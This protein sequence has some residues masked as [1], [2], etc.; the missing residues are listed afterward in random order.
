M[1]DDLK[2]SP[3]PLAEISQGP[4]AFE[5]F[6]DRNQKNL[7]VLSIIITLCTASYVV[8]S[9]I[10]KSKQET[11]GADLNKAEDTTSLQ[12]VITEHGTTKAASSAM[13][14]LADHQWTEGQQEQSIKTLNQFISTNP[15][16]PALPTAKAS[17]G[18]KL[19]L[20]GKNADAIKTFQDLSTDPKARFIAPFALISL[21]DIYRASGDIEKA[22]ASYNQAKTE[23]PES[24]FAEI[25]TRRATT[26]KTRPPEEIEPPPAPAKTDAPGVMPS[27][28]L[29]PS[30]PGVDE[31][32]GM[33]PPDTNKPAAETPIP[34]P[35]KETPPNEK[36]ASKPEAPPAKP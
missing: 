19:M 2:E 30:I 17:L 12:A 29:S 9:G 1:P 13:I 16:H 31:P 26:L 8:Y 14:L 27:S 11:A 4:G 21:G 15:Q 23:F 20:Q 33:T 3:V 34:A 18:A 7:I 36:N 28:P 24:K 5:Q 6:L 35:A 32:N 22:E 25:A 10:E